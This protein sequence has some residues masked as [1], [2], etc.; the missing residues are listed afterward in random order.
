MVNVEMSFDAEGGSTIVHTE[1]EELGI[2][3]TPLVHTGSIEADY[4]PFKAHTEV[5]DDAASVASSDE[6]DHV[7]PIA[8]MEGNPVHFPGEENDEHHHKVRRDTTWRYPPNL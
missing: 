7:L 4:N 8:D 3:G 5:D 2:D 6:V 1:A